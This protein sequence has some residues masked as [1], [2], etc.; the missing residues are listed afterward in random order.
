M[1]KSHSAIAAEVD[2]D[3]NDQI[4][5]RQYSAAFRKFGSRLAPA[6]RAKINGSAVPDWQSSRTFALPV[7]ADNP[8]YRTD[9]PDPIFET[10]D[11]LAGLSGSLPKIALWLNDRLP[12]TP[13]FDSMLA[14]DQFRLATARICEAKNPRLE[15]FLISL[16]IGMNLQDNANG[17][18]IAAH[19][20]LSPQTIH[21]MLGDTCAALGL[22]KPLAKANK[23]RY[24]KTQYSHNIRRIPK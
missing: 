16:A 21:E 10:L 4:R 11:E 22:P 20:G 19:F 2:R 15:A 9:D 8:A 13:A 7:T 1:A 14:T 18:A 3:S 5:R 24:S 17:Y 23:A 6:T 12:H